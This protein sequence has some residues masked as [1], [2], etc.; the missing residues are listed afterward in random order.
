MSRRLRSRRI[1]EQA[2]ASHSQHCSSVNHCSN[3]TA[4]AKDGVDRKR[5]LTKL[6]PR[7]RYP[8]YIAKSKTDRVQDRRERIDAPSQLPES[9]RHEYRSEK[10]STGPEV[11][12]LTQP[13]VATVRDHRISTSVMERSRLLRATIL[14]TLR[15]GNRSARSSLRAAAVP[16]PD[17]VP[18]FPANRRFICALSFGWDWFVGDAGSAGR[19]RTAGAAQ[20]CR[21]QPRSGRR[22]LA[23]SP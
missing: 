15:F 11:R 7:G 20:Q 17:P 18:S 22:A 10:P 21:R 2:R 6:T 5:A 13:L 9:M 19:P 16:S 23:Q 12:N 8:V 1:C 4:A 14:A 3:L